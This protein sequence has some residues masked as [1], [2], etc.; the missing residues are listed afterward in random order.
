LTFSFSG[1]SLIAL[2]GMSLVFKAAYRLWAAKNQDRSLP[3][4]FAV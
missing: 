3:T 4:T 1:V 2:S